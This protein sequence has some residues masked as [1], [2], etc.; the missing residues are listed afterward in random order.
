MLKTWQADTVTPS[1]QPYKMEG[2]TWKF[3]VLLVQNRT[4]NL[5]LHFQNDI[6]SFY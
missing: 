6:L 1:N 4:K 2:E 5:F 3:Q